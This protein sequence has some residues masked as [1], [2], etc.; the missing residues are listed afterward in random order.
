MRDLPDTKLNFK[1]QT[2]LEVIRLI[3]NIK[4]GQQKLDSLRLSSSMACG[5][6]F[7]VVVLYS[8]STGQFMD[9]TSKQSEIV[10]SESVEIRFLTEKTFQKGQIFSSFEVF[11]LC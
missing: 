9:F 7:I 6:G 4:N 5:P 11:S 8:Q 10:C 3:S 1:N 2:N